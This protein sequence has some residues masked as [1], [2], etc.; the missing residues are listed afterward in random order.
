MARIYGLDLSNHNGAVDFSAI[1]NAGNSFVILRAGYGN[2]ISQKDKR[3]EEY[4]AGAKA[5]GLDVGAYWYSYALSTSDA[6]R[7]AQACLTAIKGKQFEY[8]IFFDMEDADGYKAKNGMPSN[9]T[10]AAICDTFCAEVEEAGYFVGIYASS[11]WFRNQLKS[12]SSAYD[13]WYA[14]WGDADAVLDENEVR[15]DCRIHQFTSS[16]TLSGK[17]F[18]RNVVYGFDYPNTIKNAGLNGFASG[19]GS[20]PSVPSESAPDGTIF[21]L[22]TRTIQNEF[23][24]GDARKQALGDKW[25]EVMAEVNHRLL[26]DVNVIAQEVI[27]GRYGDGEDRKAAL[28]PRWQEVQDEVNEIYGQNQAQYYIVKSGDNLT[29][30][31]KAYGTTVDAIVKL[32]GISNANLIYPGQKL[33]V[34]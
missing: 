24:V 16:Y 4:Y 5:A 25:D 9:A 10:L 17:R 21:D 33:R 19:S 29:K 7:E 8:P 18:D 23:G 22:A 12:V 13:K 20:T 27:N 26:D 30:I 11:S 2:S 15:T 6:K 32:N 14:A 1:K 34:K 3:F 28:G 31:A